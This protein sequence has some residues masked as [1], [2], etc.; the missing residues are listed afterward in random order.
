MAVL[1]TP[2]VHG[3]NPWKFRNH[4]IVLWT[5]NVLRLVKAIGNS[6]GFPFVWDHCIKYWQSIARVGGDW[7]YLPW[8]G[9]LNCTINASETSRS[10]RSVSFSPR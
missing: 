8:L 9:Q 3:D 7:I 10:M 2:S 5:K 6:D 1:G 4:V